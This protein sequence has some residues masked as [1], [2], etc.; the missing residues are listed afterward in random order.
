MEL[1]VEN[2]AAYLAARGEPRADRLTIRELGGGV[3]NT[4]LLVESPERRFVLKQSL[5]RLRVKDEWLAD[6]SRILR[7]MRSLQD[8]ARFFP[9]GAVPEVLWSDEENFLF[10][11][12]AAGPESWKQYLL[13]GRIDPSLAA[14][15]GTLLGLWIRHSWGSPEFEARYG[16]QTAFD[17]LRI[18]PYYRT[19]AQRRPE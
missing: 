8:A 9:A 1:T 14:T 17:Q 5:S 11:M 2:C 7:E 12:S 15:V 3:S 4:V 6:R 19:V 10:A 18:D 16:D 13:A